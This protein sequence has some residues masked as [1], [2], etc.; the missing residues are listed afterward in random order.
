MERIDKPYLVSLSDVKKSL[1][2][3]L[4]SIASAIDF[5]FSIIVFGSP[6]DVAKYSLVVIQGDSRQSFTVGKLVHGFCRD[7]LREACGELA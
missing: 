3:L 1:F 5:V 7:V 4:L 2:A 6:E